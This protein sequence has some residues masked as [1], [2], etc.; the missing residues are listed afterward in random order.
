MV[1]IDDIGELRRRHRP[2]ATH[3]TGDSGPALP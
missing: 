2:M 3:G 1:E